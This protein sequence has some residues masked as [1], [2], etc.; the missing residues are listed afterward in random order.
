MANY[1]ETKLIVQM[2]SLARTEPL[3]IDASSVWESKSEADIYAKN[4]NAYGGQIV[5][6]LV[7]GKYKAFI[8]QPSEA[9]YTLGTVGVDPLD[10]VQYVVIGPRPT[11]G[12][13]QGVIYIDSN[14]GYIWNG[15]E[16]VKVFSDFSADVEDAKKRI[17]G[18]EAEII[19]KA[20]IESPN[21][22]GFVT[23]E[24]KEVATQEW[25]N[26]LIGQLHDGI[27]GILNSSHPLPTT[28]YKAG[29]M[30]RVA[31]YGTYAGQEC[32]PGDL[33][34][35]LKDYNSETAS[36][37]DFMIV[38]ANIDGAVTGPDAATDG[39]IVIFEGATGK[40]IKDSLISI[41][42]LKDVILKTHVHDNKAK[43]DTFDKTQSE[44]LTLVY[45][46]T[47]YKLET[48]RT[49]LEKVIE[50]KANISDVYTAE[51]IDRKV[52]EL[53]EAINGKID[54]VTVDQKIS[55][56]KTELSNEITSKIAD[57]TGK[58]PEDMDIKTYV[59]NIVGETET[60][61]TEAIN[62][63]KQEAIEASKEYV[64]SVI[65]VTEF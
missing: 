15:S 28:D 36:N 19:K 51:V 61:S 58:I 22:T 8:L 20:N 18:L 11:T 39:H 35:C 45:S 12:Q 24:E 30:W 23:I 5:S 46:D 56:A 13:Q 32:E 49:E 47:D 9:G 17:G 21:F 60:N 48:T 44:L 7:D 52:D 55:D 27:P 4:A 57:R 43:L 59:D 33:I 42:S 40:V 16:W 62:N 65:T 63:A 10:L 25:V 3:P 50:T 26:A 14:V 54:P 1:D 29:R 41:D 6:A 64:D 34:I 31:D 38:Q 37:S 53:N 2:K